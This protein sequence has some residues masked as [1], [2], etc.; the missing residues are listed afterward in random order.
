M[1]RPRIRRLDNGN[2]LVNLRDEEK[3][4]LRDLPIEL[5]QLL[6]A[7]DDDGSIFRLFPPGYANDIGRQLEYDRLMRDELQK[8]HVEALRLLEDTASR[9]ELT[10]DELFGWLKAINQ[11]RL[12]L[13]T[14][15]DIGNNDLDSEISADDP[16]V[17]AYALYEYLSLLQEEAVQ[18][19]SEGRPPDVD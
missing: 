12:V 16:R 15:L 3:I 9:P 10:E 11:L 17:S 18:A 8:R 6:E 13:G 5:I 7:G 4:V 1:S 2:F 14:R 19:A